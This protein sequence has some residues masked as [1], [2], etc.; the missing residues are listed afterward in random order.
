MTTRLASTLK[1]GDRIMRSG[2]TVKVLAIVE[3][4]QIRKYPV[5]ILTVESPSGR[6]THLTYKPNSPVDVADSEGGSS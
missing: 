2:A 3:S 4:V 1:A 5:L 6:P